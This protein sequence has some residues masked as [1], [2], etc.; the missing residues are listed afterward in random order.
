MDR[1]FTIFAGVLG[2]LAVAAGT[3]GA[4]VL[5]GQIEPDK[6]LVFETGTRYHLYHT[7]ALLV[8]AAL[9]PRLHP[10]LGRAA[11]WFFIAGILLFCGSLYI[12][13][14]MDVRDMA[15]VAPFGGFAFMI[16]WA[17]LAAA[18]VKR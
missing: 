13:T 17:L 4:H 12:Y 7:L 14:A 1:F 10:R 18:A 6:L 15:R 5:K 11:G 9:L 2:V 8:T 3:I 16:G